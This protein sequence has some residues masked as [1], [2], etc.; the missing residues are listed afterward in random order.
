MTPHTCPYCGRTCDCPMPL[1]DVGIPE[2][3]HECEVPADPDDDEHPF[4]IDLDAV[5]S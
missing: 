4:A 5:L 3:C 1:D 2:C